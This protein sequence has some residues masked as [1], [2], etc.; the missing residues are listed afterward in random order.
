MYNQTMTAKLLTRIRYAKVDDAPFLAYLFSSSWRQAYRGII[1]F[2]QLEETLRHRDVNWWKRTLARGAGPIVMI[3][4][5]TLIGYATAGPARLVK[6]PV[7]M[8][9]CGEIFEMY[10]A[11]DY[12]GV[13]LGAKL[14]ASV[15]GELRKKKLTSLLVWALSENTQACEFYRNL[16]GRP[17]ANSVQRF[18]VKNL[19]KTAFIW[20]SE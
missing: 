17:F 14:F 7:N 3:F 11:P 16:G 20:T 6:T 8:A 2:R 12:Q 4:D 10:I 13:G 18:G 5:N 9:A 15:R 19:Q 1:P